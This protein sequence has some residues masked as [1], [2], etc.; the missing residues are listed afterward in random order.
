MVWR[1][2]RMCVVRRPCPVLRGIQATPGRLRCCCVHIRKPLSWCVVEHLALWSGRLPN[3]TNLCS[4]CIAAHAEAAR[5]FAYQILQYTVGVVWSTEAT[6]DPKRDM[7]KVAALNA[8][9][10]W[11]QDMDADSKLV[12][13]NA[14][15]FAAEVVKREWPQ[16][17]NVMEIMLSC[18][19]LLKLADCRCR[20]LDFTEKLVA[21]ARM[22]DTQQELVA[23][24]LASLSEEASCTD[25]TATMPS[26]RQSEVMQ[27]SGAGVV[28]C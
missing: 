28:P 19:L 17:Y 1:I 9:S 12:K 23:L 21:I 5:L 14:V 13:A 4:E 16:R 6:L 3:L 18:L 26:Q 25:I 20:W 27:V 22:G 2:Y 24:L 10:T 8:L 11:A 7:F 15:R